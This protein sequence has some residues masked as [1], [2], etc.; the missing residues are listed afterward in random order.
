MSN[1]DLHD[2]DT[3]SASGRSDGSRVGLFTTLF[4][5][6]FL[7]YPLSIGPA[8]YLSIKGVI[9]PS[10]SN[11]LNKVYYP[12][13]WGMKEMPSFRRVVEGYG[14]W[15]IDLAGGLPP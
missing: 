12:L 5:A 1:N 7:A 14:K 2:A 11:I 6:L 4:V 9:P 8:A 10:A 3:R 15:W 13:E